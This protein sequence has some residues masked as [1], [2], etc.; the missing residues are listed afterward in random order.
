MED[1]NWIEVLTL[2]EDYGFI[3]QAFGG[4]AVLATHE[5]QKEKLGEEKY[6]K[7]QEMNKG[8]LDE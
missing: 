5:N 4:V 6:K 1:K 8:V 2:A 7:I 3:I